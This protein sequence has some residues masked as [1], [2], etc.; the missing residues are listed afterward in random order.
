MSLQPIEPLTVDPFGAGE[1][2]DG[3]EDMAQ[4]IAR[5]IEERAA[6]LAAARRADGRQISDVDYAVDEVVTAALRMAAHIA[7]SFSSDWHF[8]RV[9]TGADEME[10][11]RA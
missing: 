11:H 2:E 7:R 3:A 6:L 1:Y 9:L 8:S 4:R 5:A 10:T